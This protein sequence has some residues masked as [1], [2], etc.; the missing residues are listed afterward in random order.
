MSQLDLFL[1][2]AMNFQNDESV[3]RDEIHYYAS[4]DLTQL[5]EDEF[6][7][8]DALKIAL[9]GLFQARVGNQLDQEIML[10]HDMPLPPNTSSCDGKQTV[11]V[12]ELMA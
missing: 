12:H 8:A 3:S 6:E 1:D 5:F 11:L 4:E 2:W 7:N 10:D 9:D